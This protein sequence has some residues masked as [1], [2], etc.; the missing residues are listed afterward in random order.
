MAKN[1]HFHVDGKVG[2]SYANSTKLFS[3]DS[4]DLKFMSCKFGTAIF[5]T[6]E[7]TNLYFVAISDHLL[8]RSLNKSTTPKSLRRRKFILYFSTKP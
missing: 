1:D 6:F 8:Q 4:Y 5:N 3:V 2:S 7:V